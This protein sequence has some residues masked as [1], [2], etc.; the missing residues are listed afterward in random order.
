MLGSV[1]ALSIEQPNMIIIPVLQKLGLRI[2]DEFMAMLWN[3]GGKAVILKK[4][5]ISYVKKSNYIKDSTL[6]NE[7]I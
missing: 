3:S 4:T 1:T 7:K 6:P 5:T 2:P